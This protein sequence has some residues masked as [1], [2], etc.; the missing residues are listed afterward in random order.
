MSVEEDLQIALCAIEN[1]RIA[2]SEIREKLQLML[3]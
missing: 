1:P 2:R 3:V